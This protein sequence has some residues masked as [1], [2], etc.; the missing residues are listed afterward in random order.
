MFPIRR[1]A[2][3]DPRSWSKMPDCR[4]IASYPWLL[5]APAGAT[6]V[7]SRL[8]ER[9]AEIVGKDKDGVAHKQEDIFSSSNAIRRATVVPRR[10]RALCGRRR[11]C[12]VDTS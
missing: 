4:R 3:R 12:K 8:P 10:P 7:W 1:T 2:P 11:I 9:E 5:L 6:V